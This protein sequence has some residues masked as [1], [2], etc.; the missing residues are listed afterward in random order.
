[1]G[2]DESK[3]RQSRNAGFSSVPRV[4]NFSYGVGV[5]QLYQLLCHSGGETMRSV[6]VRREWG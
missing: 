2:E 1:M 3:P 6:A 5:V 4:N